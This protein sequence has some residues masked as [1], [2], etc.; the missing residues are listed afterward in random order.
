MQ[1]TI[2]WNCDILIKYFQ[3]YFYGLR[4]VSI[5]DEASSPFYSLFSFICMQHSKLRC[6]ISAIILYSEIKFK[7]TVENIQ[8]IQSYS[9]CISR[10][11]LSVCLSAYLSA[12]HRMLI[13]LFHYNGVSLSIYASTV[14][15]LD[16][17]R[18]FSFLIVYTV[19][20]TPWKGD[21]PVARPLPTHRITQTQNKRTQTSMRRVGF[22]PTIPAFERA[23]TVTAL[24]CAAT[25]TGQWCLVKVKLSCSARTQTL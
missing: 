16:L 11:S 21:Q 2:L 10:L 1:F 17:G 24:D 8:H 4:A 3:V 19:G 14:F 18:F 12:Q 22:E 20:R 6:K 7:E 13:P 5:V 9:R 15:S 23:K 25:V